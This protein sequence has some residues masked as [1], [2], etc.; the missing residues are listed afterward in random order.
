MPITRADVARR[1]GVS[2]AV[3]SYVL[4]PGMRPVAPATRERV[5]A[6]I[7]ELGYRPNAIAQA[8]R[9][10]PTRSIGLL[11]PDLTN[12]FF[13]EVSKAIEDAAFA[14]GRVVLV[15]ATQDDHA[16]EAAYVR[17]FADRRVD[18]L[19]MVA[20]QGHD[21]LAEVA[22]TGVPV[23]TLDRVP[24]GSPVSSICVDNVGGMA[25]AVAHLV[26]RGH[27]RIG[28]VAGPRGLRVAEDR[29]DGWRRGL[30]EAGLTPRDSDVVPA[31]FTREGGSLAAQEL[32]SDPSL[33]AVL[34]SSDVQGVGLLTVARARGIAVPER[35]SVLAFDGTALASYAD[36]PLSVVQQPVAEL[37]AAAMRAVDRV[38]AGDS[39]PT[40]VVLPT[41]LVER[42]STS[43][44]PLPPEGD[45][46]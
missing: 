25:Q 38:L 40:H 4:N 9:A 35:L 14:A 11:L 8:L 21:V 22:S 12:P 36:P 33:T 20:P 29:I 37:A 43:V 34:T 2:P 5:L 42:G 28:L 32:L 46:R 6:A 31:A 7:D 18:A 41:R 13:A 27:R 44:A 23:I 1:A 17:S 16:R 30:A 39:E 45:P 3:V 24:E 15:G 26:A 10:G 19:V